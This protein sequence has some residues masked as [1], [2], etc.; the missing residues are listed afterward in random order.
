MN[1]QLIIM[2][3]EGT[4]NQRICLDEV[5]KTARELRMVSFSAE[6]TYLLT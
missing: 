4:T 6:I 2:R 3:K 1:I 5:R